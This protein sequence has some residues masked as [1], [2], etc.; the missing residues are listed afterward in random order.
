MLSIWS[1]SDGPGKGAENEASGLAGSLGP[2]VGQSGPAGDDEEGGGIQPPAVPVEEGGE[3]WTELVADS[4]DKEDETEIPEKV[5]DLRLN[6]PAETGK[7]DSG[8]KDASDAEAEA[9]E[10]DFA[11]PEAEGDQAAENQEVEGRGRH[12]GLV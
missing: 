5:K 3:G 4:V 9:A 1:V 8:E 12:G 6:L 11:D 7:N 10:L 2:K